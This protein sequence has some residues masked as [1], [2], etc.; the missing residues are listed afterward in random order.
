MATAI[1]LI[2]DPHATI[3]PL[4]EALAIFATRNIERI[5]CLGDVAGY[6]A[7]LEGCLELIRRYKVTCIQGNHE[8]WLLSQSNQQTGKQSVVTNDFDLIQSWPLSRKVTIENTK[9]LLAHATPP[10]ILDKGIRLLDQSGLLDKSSQ[11]F[12]RKKLA[13]MQL[14]VNVLLVGHT[15]QVFAEYLGNTLVI[16]PGSC[17]Y[18]HSCAI[19]NLPEL[20]VEWIGLCNKE[21][22]KSW[23]WGQQVTKP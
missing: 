16:N 8:V 3:E 12:W 9:L 4:R 23:H 13:A 19:L 17:L 22:V 15:H 7:E 2:S 18:N 5:F 10:D 14:N 20:D 21:I 1:G 6:G 11:K